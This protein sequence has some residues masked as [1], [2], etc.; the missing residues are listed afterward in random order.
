[1]CFRQRFMIDLNT[2]MNLQYRKLLTAR[3]Y[4]WQEIEDEWNGD[5]DMNV[6]LTAAMSLFLID[7]DS[8]SYPEIGEDERQFLGQM[9]R[10]FETYP[11]NEDIGV[12]LT[13]DQRQAISQIAGEFRLDDEWHKIVAL[14]FASYANNYYPMLFIGRTILEEIL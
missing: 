9:I 1:M 14:R 6:S 12:R 13:C 3:E 2:I 11:E 5:G 4:V 7:L 10:L 8:L